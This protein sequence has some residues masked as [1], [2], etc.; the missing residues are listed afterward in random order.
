MACFLV[1][2]EAWREETEVNKRNEAF[3]ALTRSKL[4]CVVSGVESVSPVFDELR[5][6]IEQTP[7]ITFR[8]YN[9]ISLQRVIED[10]TDE[11]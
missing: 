11:S 10:E 5:S 1:E 9:K 2:P 4:W 3:V 6:L 7:S 8:A